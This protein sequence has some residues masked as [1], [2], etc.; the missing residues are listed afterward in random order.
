MIHSHSNIADKSFP[1]I[2]S[3]IQN[4]PGPIKTT[5]CGNAP[6]FL[7]RVLVPGEKPP[8]EWKCLNWPSAFNSGDDTD[9]D[10]EVE[11]RVDGVKTWLSKNKTSAK[12]LPEERSPKSTRLVLTSF[13]HYDAKPCGSPCGDATIQLHTFPGWQGPGLPGARWNRGI[14]ISYN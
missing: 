9:T 14:G 6:S 11:D 13:M 2:S 12:T 8:L 5:P 1:P 3:E 10:S 7:E 4:T